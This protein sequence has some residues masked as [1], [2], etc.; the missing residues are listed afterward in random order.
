APGPDNTTGDFLRDCHHRLHVLLTTHVASYL[1]KQ[2]IPDH[3]RTSRTV[4]LLD[5]ELRDLRS[6]YLI[7]L[8]SVLYKVFTKIILLRI[9]NTLDEAQPVEQAGFRQNF[10]CMNH[11]KAVFRDVEVCRENHLLL[12]MTFIDYERASG[13]VE[14]NS[15]LLSLVDERVYSSYIR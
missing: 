1:Y 15:V 2:K 5:G 8:P 3:W 7:C 13:S 4:I 9:S 11:I 10:C 14:T 6:Y 12:V